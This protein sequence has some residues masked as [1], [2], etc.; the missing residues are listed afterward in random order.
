V[1]RLPLLVLQSLCASSHGGNP[2]SKRVIDDNGKYWQKIYCPV[3]FLNGNEYLGLLA[4]Y[5]LYPLITLEL[6]PQIWPSDVHADVNL[7]PEVARKDFL[8]DFFGELSRGIGLNL[9]MA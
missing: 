9:N 2:G 8:S 3:Y 7:R 5:T 1:G 4:S 6:Q